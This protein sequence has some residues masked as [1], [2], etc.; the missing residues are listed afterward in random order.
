MA[1]RNL[2]RNRRRT[3]VT[4]GAMTLSLTVLMLYSGLLEGYLRN[5]ERE[6]LDYE[7]GD[8]QIFAEGYREEPSIYSTIEAPEVLL[9]QLEEGGLLATPRLLAYGLAASGESSSAASFRG[10][11]LERDARAIHVHDQLQDGRW[12]DAG[13]DRGVVIG[14]RLS[15]MLGAAPGSELLVLSQG[16][17]GS[18]AYDVFTVRGVLRGVGEATDRTGVF[19]TEA[20]FRELMVVPTGVHQI[21]VRRP[22]DLSLEQT[23]QRV[24]AAAPAGLEVLTWRELIPLVATMVD[25]ARAVIY[26]VY[27]IAYIAVAILV[28]NAML[29]AVFERVREL[30]VMKALGAGPTLILR[31]IFLEALFQAAIAIAIGVAIGVPGLIYLV[32]V[33]LDMSFVGEVAVMGVAFNPIWRA[34]FT[35]L[36]VGAPLVTLLAM[37]CVATLYPALKA[38]WLDPLQAIRH[39]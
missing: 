15:R 8:L 17:D 32:R 30:G 39:R 10:I 29:M 11:D 24:R 34:N 4:V 5:M 7:V 26:V 35:P 31:L 13:D 3:L 23:A 22:E 6:V 2:W 16:G 33:G 37:V 1:R 14:R 12:L 25:S 27:V 38:A 9:R 21:I 36:A 28:L 19:M 18:M 20:A